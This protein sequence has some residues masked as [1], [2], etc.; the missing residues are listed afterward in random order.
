M[1]TQTY[2]SDATDAQWDLIEPRL[3]RSFGGR[4]RKTDLRDVVNA[5]F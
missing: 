2:P 3:P 1:R 5:I 4:P